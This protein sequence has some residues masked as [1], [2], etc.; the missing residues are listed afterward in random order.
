M[1]PAMAAEQQVKQMLLDSGL[2]PQR[3]AVPLR[4][5]RTEASLYRDENVAP[6]S[7]LGK[8]AVEYEKIAGARTVMWESEEIPLVQ[9]YAVLEEP[10]RDRRERAWRLMDARV[11]KDTGALAD[12]WRRMMALRRQVA[13]QAG[14]ENY[15][16][17]RWQQLFRFDYTAEDAKRFHSAIEEVVV[18]AASRLY[19]QRRERLGVPMLRPW[20][21][22]VDPRGQPALHPYASIGELEDKTSAVF[23]HVDSQLG[24]YFETMRAES[25]LDLESRKNKSPGGYSLAFSVTRRPYI[26]TNAIGTHE[27]VQTLL[28]E[29]GHAFHAF[30]MAH[31][32]YLQQ[33]QEQLLPMEFL[34]VN[35]P[36]VPLPGPRARRRRPHPETTQE[37][38]Q[39]RHWLR[40]PGVG[41]RRLA[42]GHSGRSGGAV[43][44]VQSRRQR[45]QTGA[46]LA[47][48]AKRAGAGCLCP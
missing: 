45:P 39:F 32:P 33:R 6:L 8:L 43:R 34:E 42:P 1:P 13:H 19:A 3:F 30:E 48:L 25:L 7:E 41:A 29:G 31:L 40:P 28:H 24:T 22:Y 23:H 2:E 47:S 35:A 10:A 36:L 15:R 11:R 21:V 9:L 18:P 44:A 26:F 12:L 46:R 16:A 5:L 27:D 17:Y 14:F 37:P 38:G 20:D 4:K